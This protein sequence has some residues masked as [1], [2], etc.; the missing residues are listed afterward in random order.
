MLQHENPDMAGDGVA[1][2]IPKNASPGVNKPQIPY[3]RSPQNQSP[4]GAK[5]PLKNSTAHTSPMYQ[6][7]GNYNP[8]TPLD[9]YMRNCANNTTKSGNSPEF[10][11]PD[12][13]NFKHMVPQEF[14]DPLSG[15]KSKDSSPR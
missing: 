1:I 10:P 11:F 3:S 7:N 6:E 2:R 14:M 13:K 15:R 8:N 5:N 12:Q 4:R 9:M